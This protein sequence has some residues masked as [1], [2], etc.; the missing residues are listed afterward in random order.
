MQAP[1]AA[2]HLL[3]GEQVINGRPSR[4]LPRGL[5]VISSSAG[6][7]GSLPV[8]GVRRVCQEPGEVRQVSR[9]RVGDD[10]G[11]RRGVEA[12]DAGQRLLRSRLCG[13]LRGLRN[14]NR[15]TPSTKKG[16]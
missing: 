7:V 4:L 9:R 3:C 5:R 10:L 15:R 11:S 13:C 6:L 1:P 2:S 16:H 8:S 14:S 12:Q